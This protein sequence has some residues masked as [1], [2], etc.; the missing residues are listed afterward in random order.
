MGRRGPA[1][2]PIAMKILEGTYRRDRDGDLDSIVLG[3]GEPRKP[4]DLDGLAGEFWDAWVPHLVA[5]GVAKEIDSL[6]LEQMCFW[7]GSAK[8]LRKILQKISKA[9]LTKEYFR[10]Q[11]L[12]A[13][14]DK[15]FNHIASRF[16]LTPADRARLRTENSP[17]RRGVPAR[18]RS[19]DRV[20]VRARIR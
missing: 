11:V 17:V 8:E 20:G 10:V 3:E 1:K 9:A 12:T 15:S 18:D 7:W 4:D 16:G 2:K 5:L 14:A 13:Q 6:A 19:R